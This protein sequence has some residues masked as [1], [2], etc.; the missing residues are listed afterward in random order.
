MKRVTGIGGIFFKSDNPQELYQWYETHLGIQRTPDGSGSMFEWRDVGDPNKTGATVWSV[1]PRD[2]K[3]FEP[4]RSTFMINY[5]VEDLD[6]LLEELKKEGVEV[7]FRREDHDYGRFAWITD[8]DGNRIEL[9]EP[10]KK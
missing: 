5:R 10:P 3:Y 9:W 7:D 6:G 4:S 1:F 2:T 8:P